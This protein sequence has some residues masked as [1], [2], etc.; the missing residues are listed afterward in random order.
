M[1]RPL[2]LALFAALSCTQTRDALVTASGAETLVGPCATGAQVCHDGNVWTCGANRQWGLAPVGSR[3]L[4]RCVAD[5]R[6]RCAGPLL[7]AGAT[8][9]DV[10]VLPVNEASDAEVSE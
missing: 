10:L 9:P 7:D 5:P 8:M 2:Y 6:P 3:C 4:Y 1:K